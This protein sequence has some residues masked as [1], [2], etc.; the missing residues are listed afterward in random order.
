MAGS[1]R[2]PDPNGDEPRAFRIIKWR[3]RHS[4]AEQRR[5]NGRFILCPTSFD[6]L[7]Y[8]TL[9]SDARGVQ[10][11]G[12]YVAL[13]ELAGRLPTASSERTAGIL[14]NDD[15]ALTIH[16]ISV[17]IRQPRKIVSAALER[18][19]VPD[20]A[21]VDRV[22][23]PVTTGHADA[24]SAGYFTDDSRDDPGDSPDASRELSVTSA[25]APAAASKQQ[26]QQLAEGGV[27][28]GLE[29]MLRRAGVPARKVRA[30][31]DADGVTPAR[32]VAHLHDVNRR[33][34]IKSPGSVLATRF[35][36]GADYEPELS[37]EALLAAAEAGV[38]ER[39]AGEP[40]Q[41]RRITHNERGLYIDGEL[42]AS[43]DALRRGE[44]TLS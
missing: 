27:G 32:L 11:F 2:Q 3:H 40:V 42:V 17:V 37:A 39:I 38:V 13:A 18:L 8:C 20:I 29:R 12:V 41:E 25:R 31:L 9:V 14:A 23:T 10:A 21:W 7:G 19:Q 43:V 16:Q 26:Q 33:D 36:R 24:D 35:T 22:P 28:E 6:S 4:N 1:G 15:G 44:V 34:G 30:V 5:L